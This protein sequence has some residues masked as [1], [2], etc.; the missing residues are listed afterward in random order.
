MEWGEIVLLVVM[1]LCERYIAGTAKG[2]R[3]VKI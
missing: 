2:Y 1:F 3:K